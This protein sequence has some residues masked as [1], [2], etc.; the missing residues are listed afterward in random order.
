MQ[1]RIVVDMEEEVW[2]GA[3]RGPGGGRGRDVGL[4]TWKCKETALGEERGQNWGPNKLWGK[5]IG[6][7]MRPQEGKAMDIGLQPRGMNVIRPLELKNGKKT[8]IETRQR[9]IKKG[10]IVL[11]SSPLA[12]VIF[13]SHR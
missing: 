6:R 13:A 8:R 9:K 11:Q 1:G 7:N 4:R 2:Q 10:D 12:F 3:G 5:N